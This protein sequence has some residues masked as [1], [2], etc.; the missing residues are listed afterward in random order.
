MAGY[1]VYFS[2][3]A[4]IKSPLKRFSA[5]WMFMTSSGLMGFAFL[6]LALSA[7]VRSVIIPTLNRSAILEKCLEYLC[8][9][10]NPEAGWEAV[11]MDNGSTDDT[12]R[13]V[14]AYSRRLPCLRA[15]I[16]EEPG[17]HVCRN[18]GS[19]I[20]EGRILCYIDD[21]SFVSST[22]LRGIERVF[23]EPAVLLAGGPCLPEY[24]E[25][26]PGWIKTFWED[27][28]WGKNLGY[29]SLLDFGRGEKRISPYYVYG[30]N[31]NIRKSI[32]QDI[33]GFHPDGMPSQLVVFRGDGET[34]VSE[35]LSDM[36]MEAAYS[37]D[38]AVHHFVP[39]Q[40]MTE[41]YFLERAFRQGI[42]SSFSALRHAGS[43]AQTGSSKRTTRRLSYANV[44]RRFKRMARLCVNSL[45]G[46]GDGR[47]LRE[48]IEASHSAGYAFHQDAALSHEEIMEWVLRENYM[49]KSGHVP[50]S[51]D[52]P[53]GRAP[54]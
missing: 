34:Y 5:L 1:S 3:K 31:F 41:E 52:I 37:S 22:W 48:R 7:L 23:K 30:C 25:M 44:I 54:L 4:L 38:I 12:Q 13:I 2:V 46:L 36:G 15:E 18:M 47:R 8:R 42:S 39:R 11:V 43:Q 26:P 45:S 53:T 40:R 49:G 33:G 9:I 50:R 17:L 10:E 6:N 19:D 21:D 35:T 27:T 16:V 14:K 32:L 20:A 28:R 24:E 29:L 51:F